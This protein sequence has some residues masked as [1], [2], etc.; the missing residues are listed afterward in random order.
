MLSRDGEVDFLAEINP[1]K[2]VESTGVVT[3]FST[4]PAAAPLTRGD[5]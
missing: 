2:G 1:A 3:R 5:F 4:A